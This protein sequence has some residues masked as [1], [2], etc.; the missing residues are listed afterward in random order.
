[1]NY[2]NR[3]IIT[4]GPGSGKS[5]LLNALKAEGYECYDEISRTIIQEQQL[6]NGDKVPWKNLSAFAYICYER[7]TAQLENTPQDV[8][9]FDRGLPDIIAYLQRGNITAAV[10]STAV[11]PILLPIYKEGKLPL[12]LVFTGSAKIIIPQF[13]LHPPGRI[14]LLTIPNAPK[15][16]N[17]LSPPWQD[18]FINDTER[19]ETYQQSVDIYRHL[20]NTYTDLG[21]QLIELPKVSVAERVKF[22]QAAISHL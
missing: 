8:C 18:I 11:C 19:P 12:L 14:F 4:G 20:K 15:L 7:M 21:F 17:S 2:T 22:V 3:Y 5:T 9:F 16:I 1:M 6:I 13:L 10:F